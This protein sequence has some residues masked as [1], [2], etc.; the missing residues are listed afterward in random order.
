MRVRKVVT[1]SGKRFRGK[2]PSR[3][4]GRMVQ[5]E[6]LLERDAILAL[7]Y[8]H[9]VATYQEQ[10]SVEIYYDGSDQPRRY[11]PDFLAVFGDGREL[12][13]EIKPEARVAT[14]ETSEKLGAIAKRFDEQ[15]RHYRVLTEKDIRREPFF[16]NLRRLHSSGRRL[17]RASC[18][19]ALMQQLGEGPVWTISQAARQ[20]DGIEKVLQLVALSRL[21]ID[22]SVPIVAT[23]PVWLAST[24]AAGGRHGSFLL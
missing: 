1:R 20:I 14:K 17:L 12:L 7:E 21:R 4:L 15:G 5:W 24:D 13:I 19:D 6:S 18:A 22:L 2:F 3:K 10:P 23:S 16:G 8:L 11:V 9:E